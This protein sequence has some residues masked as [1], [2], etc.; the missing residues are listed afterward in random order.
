[1]LIAGRFD[2]GRR[3]CRRRSFWCLTASRDFAVGAAV[4]TPRE[5]G[6]ALA[7]PTEHHWKTFPLHRGPVFVRIAISPSVSARVLNQILWCCYRRPRR[8]LTTAWPN[9]ATG[10]AASTTYRLHLDISR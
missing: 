9:A 1:M 5:L 10:L 2:I 7:R 4:A 3:R 6:G 8:T